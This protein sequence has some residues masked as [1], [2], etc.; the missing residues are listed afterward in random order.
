MHMI[1]IKENTQRKLVQRLKQFLHNPSE[2]GSIHFTFDA[3][4]ANTPQFQSTIKRLIEE[5][6]ASK[7]VTVYACEDGEMLILAPFIHVREAHMLALRIVK[8]LELS[9]IECGFNFSDLSEH[10]VKLAVSLERK[11]A[12]EEKKLYQEVKEQEEQLRAQQKR[13]SILGMPVS[14]DTSAFIQKHRAARAAAEIM[15]IEDDV[16]SRKLVENALSKHYHVTGLGETEQALS[17]YI[18]LAPN[19]LFLDINL[20]NVTGHELLE[21]V[22][23]LDPSAYVVMLSGN[24]DQSNVTEALKRGAKGFVAKPFTPDKLHQ[25]IQRC[26]TIH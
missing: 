26:P 4:K 20:P 3:K 16:F 17:S 7:D 6:I 8:E 21:K 23:L 5:E 1:I 2:M 25:Y 13:R 18:S 14:A 11:I 9:T 19:V 24:A 10:A 22:L 12:L 15:V